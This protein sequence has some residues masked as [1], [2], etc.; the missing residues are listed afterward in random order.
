MPASKG[1]G[2]QFSRQKTVSPFSLPF[3]C[4]KSTSANWCLVQ[5]I[6][7]ILV[8]QWLLGWVRLIAA[9]AVSRLC[10]LGHI[11]KDLISR[12]NQSTFL[13]PCHICIS[14]C[15]KSARPL[16]VLTELWMDLQ[17]KQPCGLLSSNMP[18]LLSWG[19]NSW[20]QIHGI[21]PTICVTLKAT[22]CFTDGTKL[23]FN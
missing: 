1:P 11:I 7:L 14:L 18:H 9:T 21:N 6:N 4:H 16:H 3:F 2:L 22:Q 19:Q 5:T 12:L 10:Y 17:F 13:L 15:L 20:L 8:L 23:P